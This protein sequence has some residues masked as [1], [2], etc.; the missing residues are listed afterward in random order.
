MLSLARLCVV[1]AAQRWQLD[2][3]VSESEGLVCIVKDARG[4]HIKKTRRENRRLKGP[5]NENQLIFIYLH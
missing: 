2:C 5:V 1:P 4:L 3:H